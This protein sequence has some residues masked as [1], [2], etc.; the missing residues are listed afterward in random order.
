VWSHILLSASSL[1]FQDD[2]A[3]NGNFFPDLNEWTYAN[4][5]NLDPGDLDNC[6]SI[7]GSQILETS[8]VNIKTTLLES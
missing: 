7:L 4:R 6:I 8:V 5:A 3:E 2:V 1:C